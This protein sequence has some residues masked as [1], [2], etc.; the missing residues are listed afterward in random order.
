MCK[1]PAMSVDRLAGGPPC[2]KAM[3]KNGRRRREASAIALGTTRSTALTGAAAQH[4]QKTFADFVTNAKSPGITEQMNTPTLAKNAL[5]PPV[6]IRRA[7]SA[8]TQ[9]QM[10]RNG[11]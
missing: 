11:R 10:T 6:L 2:P 1:V 7:T 3:R 4:F 5:H 8:A 9:R